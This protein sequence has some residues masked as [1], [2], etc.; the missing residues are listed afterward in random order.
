MFR[1][2]YDAPRHTDEECARLLDGFLLPPVELLAALAP[3][4]WS[5]SPLRCCYHPTPEQRRQEAAELR[6][7][8]ERRSRLAA[9]RRGAADGEATHDEAAVS[10]EGSEDEGIE[11]DT[12]PGN[13]ERE[14][15]DLVGRV[16]WDV[17]SDNHTVFDSEGDFDLG[18]FRASAGFLAEEI[19]V[20]YRRLGG[21]R[22]YLSFYMGTLWLDRRADLGPVY[23]WV[24]AGLRAAGCDWRYCFPRIYLVSLARDPEPAD[25]FGPDPSTAV[26]AELEAVDRERE[27]AEMQ[28]RMDADYDEAVE[29]AK[30]RPPPTIVRAYH[31][32]YGRW[33]R[34]WPPAR[35]DASTDT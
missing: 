12:R 28:R 20:R 24:F 5:D 19:N 26:L 4:G 1:D 30:S 23:R 29:E 18:S 35:T 15:V 6:G 31:D 17:F 34:G 33:P 10:D 16:L 7:H 25:G 27:R 3:E 21:R 32:V 8:L 2:T 22:D 13:A 11:E 14:V 9:S